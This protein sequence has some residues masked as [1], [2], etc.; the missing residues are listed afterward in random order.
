[1]S[2]FIELTDY[3][4]GLFL[5]HTFGTSAM[6]APTIYMALGRSGMGLT[7]WSRAGATSGTEPVGNGYART[8]VG[9]WDAATDFDSAPTTGGASSVNSDPIVFPTQTPSGWGALAYGALFDAPTGGNCLAFF[10]IASGTG[11]AGNQITFGAGEL[12]L[13][14]IPPVSQFTF[15]TARMTIPIIE[16]FLDVNPW[17]PPTYYVGLNTAANLANNTYTE[18][19]GGSYARVAL[20]SCVSAYLQTPADADTIGFITANS[21]SVVFPTATADWPSSGSIVSAGLFD[22]SSGGNLMAV[23]DKTGI[24]A[25][26]ASGETAYIRTAGEAD[27]GTFDSLG[28][29]W[30]CLNFYLDF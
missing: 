3:A 13:L 2:A 28:V 25:S 8:L 21:A 18:V 17:T 5:D 12:T 30:D 4:R 11:T 23:V 26:I 16:H 1:M 22:A 20:G 29:G 9:P 10:N 7:G 15:S 14:L 24:A 6:T 19:S 27:G